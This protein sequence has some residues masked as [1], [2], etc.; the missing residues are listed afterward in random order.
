ML[1]H[2]SWSTYWTVIV[3]SL[4]IYYSYIAWMNRKILF[5]WRIAT[6]PPALAESSDELFPQADA[7]GRELDAYLEQTA[8]GKPSKNEL[9]FGIHKIIKK[10]SSL[11]GTSYEP[12]LSQLI[13][14]SAT[15]KCAIHLS[16]EDI[17]QV[18]LV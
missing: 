13:V 6:A 7:C 15:D 17:R 16:E 5:T 2:I 8:Y 18:W 3:F 4:L 9:V 10:Y 14:F 11:R 1:N 12:A